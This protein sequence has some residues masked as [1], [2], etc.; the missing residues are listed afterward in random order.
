[1]GGVVVESDVACG[2]CVCGSAAT[3][4]VGALDFKVVSEFFVQETT[5]RIPFSDGCSFVD[6]IVDRD[7][8]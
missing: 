6:E 7:D 8:L 2:D 5:F 1:M 3:G 4:V